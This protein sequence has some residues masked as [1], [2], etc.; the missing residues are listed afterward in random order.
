LIKLE[1]ART[2]LRLAESDDVTVIIDYYTSNQAHL[3]PFEPIRPEDFY[4]DY[5]Y[6]EVKVR[7]DAFNADHSL[8][9][10]L[11]YFLITCILNSIFPTY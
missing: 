10:F 5:W 9:L 4:T 3:A 1:S 11:Y 7:L 2:I 8:K 6:K